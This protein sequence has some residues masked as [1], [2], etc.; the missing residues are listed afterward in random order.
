MFESRLNVL[1]HQGNDDEDTKNTVDDAGD[2]GEKIDKKFERVGN[3][4]GG[5]LGEKNGGANAQRNGN[6]QRN[7]SGDDRSVN[8]WQSA[9][10]FEDGVPDGGTKEI[11][12]EL[13]ARESGTLP[14]LEN[15]Q[16]GDENDGSGE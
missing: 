9:E 8:K 2:G 14:Q 3:S 10:L 6:Q 4:C 13:V 5:K 16:H 15:E 11:E 7:G 12:A 1:A